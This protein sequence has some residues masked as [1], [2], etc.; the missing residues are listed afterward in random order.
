[1]ANYTLIVV[2]ALLLGGIAVGV[3]AL[4]DWM[5]G[6]RKDAD[7]NHAVPF[8]PSLGEYGNVYE[9]AKRNYPHTK[10][11]LHLVPTDRRRQLDLAIDSPWLPNGS[12]RMH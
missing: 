4:V 9:R 12:R 11:R 5:L 1:M 7:D 2:V 8:G 10:E 3:G 6:P